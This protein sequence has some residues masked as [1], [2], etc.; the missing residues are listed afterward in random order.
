MVQLI[1]YTVLH[2]VLSMTN[3][4][5]TTFFLKFSDYQLLVRTGCFIMQVF[6]DSFFLTINYILGKDLLLCMY[7][8]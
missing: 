2:N 3:V 5:K 6:F 7:L 4:Q 1:K 8:F